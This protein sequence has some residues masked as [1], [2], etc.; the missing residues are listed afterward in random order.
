MSSDLRHR[1]EPF[2]GDS[3]MAQ[4]M[5]D[6]DWSK[7]VL[8]P[9]ENWPA[10]LLTAVRIM[11]GSRYAMWLG[12]GDD[13]VF[14]YNDAYAKMTL[15]PKHPSALGRPFREVWSEIWNDLRP[16]AEKVLRTGEATWDEGLLLFLERQGFPE[17][18]YHT[19]SYS[20]LPDDAGGVGG[21]LCVVTEDTARTIGERRLASL[22]ELAART[23][24]EA[25]STE[26]ACQAA[27]KILSGN[28]KDVPFALI[29]LLSDDGQCAHL[30]GKTDGILV[31]PTKAGL[32][33]R[34]SPWPFQ[35]VIKQGAL[36]VDELSSRI[37]PLSVGP[38]PENIKQALVLPVAKP[39][40][41]QLAGFLV[42]GISPRRPFDDAYRGFLELLAVQIATTVSS[43]RAFEEEKKRAEKL[44]EL[45]RAKTAFFS[46]VS[47]EFRTP[48]TLM[49]GPLEDALSDTEEKLSERQRSRQELVHRNALRLL[50]LVNSL[51]DFSRI[52]AGRIDA[53]FESTELGKFT[54]DLASVFRS[55]IEKAGIRF[56]VN[57]PDLNVPV[58]V[59]REMWEKIVLNL[60]SNALKFTFEGEIEMK[61]EPAGNGVAFSIRD[62]GTGIPEKEQGNLF[63]RFHRIE[64]AK[65][66][67]HEGTGIGLALIHELVRFHGGSIAVK[68]SEG[69]GSEFT[70]TL[71]LG[72]AHLPSDQLGKKRETSATDLR[73]AAFVEEAMGWFSRSGRP[74][75]YSGISG[76]EKG[77]MELSV[78]SKRSSARLLLADDNADMRDYVSKVLSSYWTVE[79]C[80][81]GEAALESIRRSVPDL[82][83]SDVMMPK[84]DGFELLRIL[85]EDESTREL[86]VILLS[87]RAGEESRIEGLNKG[88][89]DYLVKP[90][91]AKE[92]LARVQ[93][94][95]EI[96]RIRRE[97]SE[98]LRRRAE[99]LARSNAEL[100]QFA[101]VASHDLK[102]PLRVVRTHL[103]FVQK[104]VGKQLEETPL[105][106]MQFAMD[107]SSRM[108]DLINDLLEYARVGV[109]EEKATAVPVG[110][111]LGDVLETLATSINEA[112]ATVYVGELPIVHAV[113]A[114]ARQLLQNLIA[115]AIK[116]RT[117]HPLKVSVSA[118]TNGSFAI[119]SVRDNGIGF[120]PQ[121]SNK[122]FELFQ[123]LHHREKYPGTGIGLSICKKIVEQHGGKIWAESCPGEG[124]VF[125]FMLPLEHQGPQE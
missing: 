123:R 1:K 89:N 43:A 106:H 77:S 107:A 45:D 37:E 44:A 104:L 19:F 68:S 13:L 47:H 31:A 71:P 27:A 5:R 51:L 80:S 52:E 101:Y 124:S 57:V 38:F 75:E 88:A 87:A 73:S 111:A 119:L 112:G 42:A 85:R 29:Y 72:S 115:N 118:E 95:I 39:G 81:N 98:A 60:L 48:I 91:S 105:K 64:G 24:D 65:G 26:D 120:D 62:T 61:L 28:S 2:S 122:I 14:L 20:P 46:N 54:R 63:R 3:E 30:A 83:I 12:W 82:V 108:Y 86:P 50:K 49:L 33:D 79:T 114:Q 99:E 41:A 11:L 53:I 23:P 56:L 59:D 113:P 10:S 97:A 25:K 17:E 84:L 8:G 93:S 58:F 66:R 67:S 40:Q 70:V 7:T 90:F 35:N 121:Y 15:G 22:R 9:V 102:E 18:T 109:S 74:G 96:S 76:L 21:L 16:R 32:V 4:R 100:S 103:Q 78:P 94:Q 55:A 69:L 116:Y 36:I 125:K 6:F 34:N 117:E 110:E 92:L